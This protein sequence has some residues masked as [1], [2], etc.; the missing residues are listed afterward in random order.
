MDT[1]AGDGDAGAVLLRTAVQDIVEPLGNTDARG[2]DQLP[3]G[4]E[5]LAGEP[6]HEQRDVGRDPRAAE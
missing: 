1:L 3:V 2:V 5:P 4:V 6:V